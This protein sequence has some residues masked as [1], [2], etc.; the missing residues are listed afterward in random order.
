M[1]KAVLHS[2]EINYEEGS[3]EVLFHLENHLGLEEFKTI[4]D[5]AR[6]HGKAYFPD[7]EGHHFMLEYKSGEYF[8]LK[9]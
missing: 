5:H 6:L 3:K 4:F 8:L 1:E 9:K 7:R 2:C